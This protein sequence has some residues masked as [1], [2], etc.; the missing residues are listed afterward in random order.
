MVNWS[1]DPASL[2]AT[3]AGSMSSG[4]AE[5]FSRFTIV[6]PKLNTAESS[7]SNATGRPNT[8]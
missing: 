2:G 8:S 4:A 1:L 5:T 3:V 7:S 6:F